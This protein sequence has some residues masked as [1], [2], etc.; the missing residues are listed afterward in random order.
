MGFEAYQ[1]SKRFSLERKSCWEKPFVI[2]RIY[3]IQDASKQVEIG[4]LLKK[5]KKSG[6]CRCEL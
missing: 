6:T 5:K 4:S 2:R 3:P 1:D